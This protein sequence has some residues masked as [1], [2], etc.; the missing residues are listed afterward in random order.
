MC[1]FKQGFGCSRGRG[2]GGQQWLHVSRRRWCPVQCHRWRFIYLFLKV[3][4]HEYSLVDDA[5]ECLMRAV[6][7][8]A[9]I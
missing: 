8:S 4:E 5:R 6:L 9:S 2:G 1:S 7:G 3:R